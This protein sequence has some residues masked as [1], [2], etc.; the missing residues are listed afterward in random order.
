M[1]RVAV[2]EKI[3]PDL[4]VAMQEFNVLIEEGDLLATTPADDLLQC[5]NV[6]GGLLDWGGKVFA[7]GYMPLLWDD[8][9]PKVTWWLTLSAEQIAAIAYGRLKKLNLW[10]C[11]PDCRC[12]FTTPHEGECELCEL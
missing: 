6:C 12:R 10:R 11:D 5:E 8:E 7:F 1:I 3:P 9:A 4:G 2:T